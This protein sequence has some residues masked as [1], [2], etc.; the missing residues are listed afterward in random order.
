MF[1]TMPEVSVITTDG[2]IRIEQ[3]IVEGRIAT[4]NEITIDAFQ[5]PLLCAWLRQAAEEVEGQ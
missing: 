1:Q 2:K 3:N 4:T 5:V